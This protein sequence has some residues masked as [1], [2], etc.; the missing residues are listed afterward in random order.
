MNHAVCAITSEL[1]NTFYI[2][3]A[4]NQERELKI[5]FLKEIQ[6]TQQQQKINNNSVIKMNYQL[7]RNKCVNIFW[8]LTR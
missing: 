6:H 2:T 8:A 3:N 5:S 4:N 7:T 1:I